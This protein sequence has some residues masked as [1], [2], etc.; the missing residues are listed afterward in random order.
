MTQYI[1]DLPIDIP[2]IYQSGATTVIRRYN[3]IQIKYSSCL[4][5]SGVAV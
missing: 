2:S 1:Y 5:S 4:F 3:I